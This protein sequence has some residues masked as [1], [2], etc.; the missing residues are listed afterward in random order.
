[1]LW[2][3]LRR[4]GGPDCHQRPWETSETFGER[5]KWTE[6]L[7][8]QGRAE[9]LRGCPGNGLARRYGLSERTVCRWTLERSRGGRPRQ[10]GRAIGIDE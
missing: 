5:S 4:F 10:L 1:M 3:P 8:H 9:F 7:S 6:R 2:L